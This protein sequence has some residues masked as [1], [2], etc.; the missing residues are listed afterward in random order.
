MLDVKVEQFEG[1]LELLVRLIENEKLPITEVSLAAVTDQY[2]AQLSLRSADASLD[3]LAD[4]LVVAARL[5]LIKSRKLLPQISV[6]E[7]SEIKDLERR[8]KIYQEF[9]AAAKTLEKIYNHH[10]VLFSRR[11]HPANEAVC[12]APPPRLRQEKLAAVMADI[13]K[14]QEPSTPHKKFTFD[15]RISVQEKIAAL[16]SALC[17]RGIHSFRS[18][19]GT[20]ASRSDLIVSFLALL[21]IVKQQ[22]ATV[23]QNAL[24]DDIRIER[25]ATSA[26]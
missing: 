1:P 5:L 23:A 2:L 20:D 21:E 4:F 17:A 12:F 9:A 3:D 10:R 16:K 13:V 18:L 25:C 15:S 26:S 22:H 19:I 11:V 6:E 24:F 14:K 8:L 7:E